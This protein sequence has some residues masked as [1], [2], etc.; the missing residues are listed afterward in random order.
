MSDSQKAAL[1]WIVFGITALILCITA[2]YSLA[3]LGQELRLYDIGEISLRTAQPILFG[4]VGALIIS[5]RPDNVIGLLLMVLSVSGALINPIEAYL[6]AQYPNEA[7]V[8]TTL[9][10]LALWLNGWNWLLLVIPI[11]FI[12]VL[13]PTGK[14][15]TPRWRW[16]IVLGI[17]VSL[18]MIVGSTFA[19]EF[20]TDY[21]MI[22]NPIGFLPF[23]QV[24][25]YL[26]IPTTAGLIILVLGCPTALFVRYY[27]TSAVERQQIKWLFYAGALFTTAFFLAIVSDAYEPYSLSIIPFELSILAIPVAIGSAILR[28]RLYD[29]DIII[30][31]TLLYGLLTAVLLTVYF[32]L[33][34]LTQSAFVAFTGQQSPL[35]VVL[36]TLVIAALFNPLRRRLQAFIDR[37]F[38]RGDY[39]AAQ[40]VARFAHAAR[41]EVETS[42]L[43]ALLLAAIN[44]TVGPETAVVWLKEPL[45][46]NNEQLT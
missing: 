9:F 37:R 18:T 12:L 25:R 7:A 10:Y 40:T 8:S 19:D 28:Y 41:D 27:R 39:D 44:E 6:A 36:S 20:N 11:L 21:G 34:L 26:E 29:I 46:V 15:L 32:G 43:T 31:K 22:A 2:F 42:S 38:H 5:R 1:A 13:F 3:H 30:R 33:V 17:T 45:T 14:P 4:L 23:D 24:E 16:L 35:A